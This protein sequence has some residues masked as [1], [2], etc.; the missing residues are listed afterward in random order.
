MFGENN[1]L[2][3]FH[4]KETL[5]DT[6]AV[7]SIHI[8]WD[9]QQDTWGEKVAYISPTILNRGKFTPLQYC[10]KWNDFFEDESRILHICRHPLDVWNSFIQHREK[11]VSKEKIIEELTPEQHLDNL[12]GC[13]RDIVPQLK[14]IPNLL[15]FKYEDLVGN[16][17]STI[18]RLYEFCNLEFT[19]DIYIQVKRHLYWKRFNPDRVFAYQRTGFDVPGRNFASL[20]RIY[21]EHVDGIE[22]PY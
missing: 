19:D 5:H 15:A 2:T 7:D 13:V 20:V 8:N 12:F 22:Y 4:Q 11:L 21:N 3:S 16:P 10:E 14:T 18:K 6:T 9:L 1:I 17:T